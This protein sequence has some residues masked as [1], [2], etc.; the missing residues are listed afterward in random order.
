MNRAWILSVVCAWRGSGP[1][2]PARVPALT[3]TRV[4]GYQ[5]GT[6]TEAP[7]GASW[8]P[9]DVAMGNRQAWAPPALPGLHMRTASW[10]FSSN[11]WISWQKLSFRASTLSREQG[12]R[13]QR[14]PR[15]RGSSSKYFLTLRGTE[16]INV[17]N[18]IRTFLIPMLRV[19]K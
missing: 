8:R 11:K 17:I 2:P 7:T 1:A 5:R 3:G 12:C 16:K 14:F 15:A 6:D 13:I 4:R 9:N 18:Y 10:S 19:I